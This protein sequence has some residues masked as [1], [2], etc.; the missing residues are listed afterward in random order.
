M[1]REKI[2]WDKIYKDFRTRHPNFAKKVLGFQPYDYGKIMLYFS[3][4]EK[5]VYDF[6]TKKAVYVAKNSD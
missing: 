3:E 5:M 1:R 4:G 2:T 6:D